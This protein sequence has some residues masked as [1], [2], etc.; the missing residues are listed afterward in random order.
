MRMQPRP[1][2]SGTAIALLIVLIVESVIWAG[3][4]LVAVADIFDLFIWAAICLIVL[5]LHVASA[6]GFAMKLPFAQYIT[7]V[8][9][10]L[11]WIG[12][13]LGIVTVVYA[14]FIF[15]PDPASD[16]W[17]ELG[18]VIVIFLGG[19]LAVSCLLPA[20]TKTTLLS[21]RSTK[22]WFESL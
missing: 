4:F 3:L 11:Y 9:T 7:W 21:V 15:S 22:K 18:Q 10:A 6:I 2:F 19:I 5:G 14:A 1:R 8:L 16:D 12:T 13:L 20:I 17:D